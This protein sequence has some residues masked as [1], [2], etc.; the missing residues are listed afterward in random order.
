MLREA[1]LEISRTFSREAIRLPIQIAALHAAFDDVRAHPAQCGRNCL[2]RNTKLGES[3][4]RRA[5]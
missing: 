3:P 5:T 4:W 1:T 2:H